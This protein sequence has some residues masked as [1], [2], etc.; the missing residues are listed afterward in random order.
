MTESEAAGSPARR[1]TRWAGVLALAI[2]PIAG[3]LTYSFWPS[4]PPDTDPAETSSSAPDATSPGEDRSSEDERM[5]AAIVGTW[6][7][8]RSTGHRDLVIR[9]DG[10]ATM[11][12]NIESMMRFVFGSKVELDI[13]WSVKDGVLHFRMVGGKPKSSVDLL[14]S[15]YGDSI[16][17]RILEL[18]DDRL[19]VKDGGDDPD[20]DWTRVVADEN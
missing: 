11:V 4:P 7:T 8:N 15:G 5:S 17:Y 3:G 10:T 2:V 19:L 18:S 1:R 9:E 14:T 12:V 16:A 20:H 13:E 6:E